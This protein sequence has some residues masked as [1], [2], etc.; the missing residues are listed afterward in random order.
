[1]LQKKPE[2]RLDLFTELRETNPPG[3]IW[4]LGR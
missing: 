1:V 2:V 3:H 4:M